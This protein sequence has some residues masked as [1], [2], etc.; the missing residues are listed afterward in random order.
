MINRS[1]TILKYIVGIGPI[2]IFI[3]L[4]IFL[5]IYVSPEDVVSYV[6]VE[7]AYLLMFIVAFIGGLTTFNV[8]PYYSLLFILSGGELN[9]F[10]L[11]LSSG[12][13]I[14]LGDSTTYFVGFQSGKIAP[15]KLQRFFDK[16]NQKMHKY[17]KL[18]P[19]FCFVYGS[20]SPLSNDF[21]TMSSGLAKYPFFKMIVPL[22]LGNLIFNI[23]VAYF[24]TYAYD[25][26]ELSFF[27]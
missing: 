2:V 26:I 20:L 11:G 14:V 16:V 17:P 9:P 6:G 22:G 3:V 13:G 27:Q 24:F 19:V 8:V 5:Y 1:K 12:L 18:F 10:I 7:N 21:I 25:F 15:G 23:S 4:S